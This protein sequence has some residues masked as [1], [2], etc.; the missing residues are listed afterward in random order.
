MSG[1]K[2]SLEEARK[3]ADAVTKG[4]PSTS[5]SGTYTGLGVNA[6]QLECFKRNQTWH[7][8]NRTLCVLWRLELPSAVDFTT[9][10]AKYVHGTRMRFNREQ[11]PSPDFIAYGEA[12]STT[13][14][15]APT[16]ITSAHWDEFIKWAKKFWA[17]PDFRLTERDYKVKA[18]ARVSEAK[19]LLDR[20][21]PTWLKRL[22]RSFGDGGLTHYLNHSKWL[23][24]W[25]KE[26]DVAAA[27]L[28]ELWAGQAELPTRLQ[29]FGAAV[30]EDIRGGPGSRLSIATF[31]LMG[32]DVVT[33]PPYQT[34]P[35][36]RAYELTGYGMPVTDADDGAI[37][38][39]AMAFL[40]RL[41]QEAASRGLIIDDRLDAQ[42]LVWA[43]WKWEPPQAWTQDERDAFL[44]YRG[45]IMDHT[46]PASPLMALA[47]TLLIPVGFLENTVQLLQDKRQVIF[48]GP[49][50]TGKTFVAQALAKALTDEDVIDIVQFHPS[51][52]YE[53]FVQGFRPVKD[54]EGR[55][56]FALK[57]GPLKRMA[58]SAAA[59][60]ETPHILII[61]ELNRGNIA[62]VFGEL[63]F[64]L[65]YRDTSLSLQYSDEAFRLPDNLWI[66]GTMNTADRSI[67]LVDAALRRRFYFQGFFPD[68][69]P[70]EGLLK[71]WLERHHPG[72]T[73]VADVDDRANARLSDRQASI[74]PSHF[75]RK[76]LDEA[77]V[78]RIWEHSVLPTIEEHFFGEP[79]RLKEFSLDLLRGVQEAPV[80]D[81]EAPGA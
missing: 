74:G 13:P 26:P 57:D 55:A 29:A 34:R 8:T 21:E 33:M 39:H 48:Y 54:S 68:R 81:R 23:A 66:I 44:R 61:D 67:A 52:A 35:F 15:P 50:G 14:P 2:T 43:I 72:L 30:P 62:K 25:Q 70:V 40:D 24:W 9:D 36:Q 47:D 59:S 16:Q 46:S 31:L 27:V 60:P 80:E 49:P 17:L 51:Y 71:R 42:G 76:T 69:A 5:K 28:R 45:G 20:G 18:A 79:E 11:S 38:S 63:F 41:R 53:D 22:Q 75:M 77:W 6:F 58:T 4:Y 56:A 12:I 65:E 32:V 10:C 7:F 73:W 78:R 19:A 1:I 64:L 37:H 3:A